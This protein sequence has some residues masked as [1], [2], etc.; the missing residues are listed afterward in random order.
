[1]INK[2]FVIIQNILRVTKPHIIMIFQFIVEHSPSEL[3][4]IFGSHEFNN[5]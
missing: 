2:H 3:R 4:K 1:M 5:F